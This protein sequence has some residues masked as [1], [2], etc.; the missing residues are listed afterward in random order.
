MLGLMPEVCLTFVIKTVSALSWEICPWVDDDLVT[1][2]IYL[3]L[4]PPNY[5]N[6]WNKRLLVTVGSVKRMLEAQVAKY[7][8]SLQRRKSPQR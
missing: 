8:S 1:E 7:T 5:N 6:I 4:Q 3:G 2:R